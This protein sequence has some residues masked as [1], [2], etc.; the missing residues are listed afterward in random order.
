M[1]VVTPGTSSRTVEPPKNDV[2]GVLQD[3]LRVSAPPDFR[4]KDATRLNFRAEYFHLLNHMNLGDRNLSQTSAS[5]SRIGFDI[6]PRI[7]QLSLKL[8]L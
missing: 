3:A 8:L 6:S 4:I 1:D 2:R 5:F 7:T